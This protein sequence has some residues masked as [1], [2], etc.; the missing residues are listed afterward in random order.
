M[1][2]VI[3][4]FTLGLMHIA[5]PKALSNV[6]KT[7]E[8]VS[9]SDLK[10]LELLFQDGKPI[11]E[12]N[13]HLIQ[14]SNWKCEMTGARSGMQKLRGANLYRIQKSKGV[15]RNTGSQ[16]IKTYAFENGDFVGSS[17][18]LRDSLRMIDSQTLISKLEKKS[19]PPQT[20]AFSNCVRTL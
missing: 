11:D 7:I 9:D 3:L 17:D 6:D 2:R 4:S 19:S 12:N 14:S 20:V 13:I 8:F 1:I 18:I 15:W 16:P 5:L 10:G